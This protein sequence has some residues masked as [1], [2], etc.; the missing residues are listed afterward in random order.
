MTA[1]G[2]VFARASTPRCRSADGF[3]RAGDFGGRTRER[4]PAPRALQRLPRRGCAGASGCGHSALRLRTRTVPDKSRQAGS[5]APRKLS[6]AWPTL[7]WA[8][9]AAGAVVAAAV[10]L[11]H[12]GKLNQATLPSVNQQVATTAPPAGRSQIASSS[13]PSSP[14]TSSPSAAPTAVGRD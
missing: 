2:P 1:C 12:P 11:V 7:R 6:L 9:L 5:R 10:V 4:T 3:C 14:V 8:A 13:V